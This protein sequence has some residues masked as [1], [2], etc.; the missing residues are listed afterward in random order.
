[1]SEVIN[2]PTVNE[3][4]K[5]EESTPLKTE[6]KESDFKEQVEK[7]KEDARLQQEMEDAMK[8]IEL[9]SVIDSI[10][11][12]KDK[13]PV[14]I[15][16][17]TRVIII[18]YNDITRDMTVKHVKNV[19]GLTNVLNVLRDATYQLEQMELGRKM[20]G[21]INQIVEDHCA[22]LFANL[23]GFKRQ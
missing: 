21:N 12:T 18:A 5:M 1:M 16:K 9:K 7:E 4:E 2:V 11:W 3:E 19:A 13:Q 14:M 20:L 6:K 17:D 10:D 8:P 23:K 15:L 22:K